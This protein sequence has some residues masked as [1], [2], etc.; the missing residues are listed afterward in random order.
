M[1]ETPKPCFW[2]VALEGNNLES[3]CPTALE[4]GSDKQR[5]GGAT[6]KTD[7]GRKRQVPAVGT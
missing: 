5:H 4:V 3:K 7:T 2:S 6:F 1:S